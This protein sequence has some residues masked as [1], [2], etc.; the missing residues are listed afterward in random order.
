M[1]D[2]KRYKIGDLVWIPAY[3]ALV[4]SREEQN[5]KETYMRE[6]KYGLVVSQDKT[7]LRVLVEQSEYYVEKKQVY[8]AENDYQP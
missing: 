1:F 2:Y 3:T 8:G 6:P 4:H 7:M 5:P